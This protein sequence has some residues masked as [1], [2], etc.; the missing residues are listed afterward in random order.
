MEAIEN[1]KILSVRI[2]LDDADCAK[3]LQASTGL[4]EARKVADA[5]LDEEYP[6]MWRQP[7]RAHWWG[8]DEI[9]VEYQVA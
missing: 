1:W 9:R 8:T 5:Y 3:G 4:G 6:G 7:M 2:K